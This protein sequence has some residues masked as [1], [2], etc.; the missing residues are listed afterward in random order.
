[1]GEK[2]RLVGK[3][4]IVLLVTPAIAFCVA[5]TLKSLYYTLALLMITAFFVF[6]HAIGDYD[7]FLSA[8]HTCRLDDVRI[9]LWSPMDHCRVYI[10]P[11]S[12]SVWYWPRRCEKYWTKN[13]KTFEACISAAVSRKVSF[14]HG[15]LDEKQRL[16]DPASNAFSLKECRDAM[17]D[18]IFSR[19]A[20][21]SI[22][23]D[24]ER[25]EQ[26]QRWF[27]NPGLLPD[28]VQ[29][30]RTSEAEV[31][32]QDALHGFWLF[33]MP[34]WLVHPRS[35]LSRP[36]PG[37][38][39]CPTREDSGAAGRREAIPRVPERRRESCSNCQEGHLKKIGRDVIM[40]LLHWETLVLQTRKQPIFIGRIESEPVRGR[41]AEDGFDG[42]KD[43]LRYACSILFQ[44]AECQA[45]WFDDDELLRSISSFCPSK[46]SIEIDTGPYAIDLWHLCQEAD[47]TAL[48]ALYL[49]MTV[50]AADGG[51]RILFEAAPLKTREKYI[52]EGRLRWRHTWHVAIVCQMI[53]ML[54]TIVSVFLGISSLIA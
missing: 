49:W 24:Y 25:L 18:V 43:A 21:I 51:D 42:F 54:T 10:L 4:V 27:M 20:T 32:K 31:E 37:P 2:W 36:R 50:W 38:S 40:A 44:R 29:R 1:M 17:R 39:Q 26:L 52:T 12:K 53:V 35:W 16:L 41:S 48:G 8:R 23:D 33:R 11:H 7:A 6:I 34:R 30:G 13:P 28:S 46:P 5:V 9:P 22:N 15:K 3:V 14:E 47:S 45:N 19:I